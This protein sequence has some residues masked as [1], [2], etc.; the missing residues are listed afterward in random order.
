M[1]EFLTS[2]NDRTPRFVQSATSRRNSERH[3]PPIV[4][5]VKALK[6]QSCLIDGQTVACEDNG[7]AVFK[8]LNQEQQGPHIS[9]MPSTC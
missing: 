7:I 6:M 2:K 9:C 1:P 8:L 4:Q 3:H 5:A